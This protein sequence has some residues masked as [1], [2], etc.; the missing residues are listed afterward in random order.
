[1]GVAH[2]EKLRA[3]EVAS[4]HGTFGTQAWHASIVEDTKRSPRRKR[5]RERARERE[6][7][8]EREMRSIGV[9]GRSARRESVC[10]REI[11][12]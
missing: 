2:R 12:R 5:E 11:E 3:R 6:R 7:E 8:R 10:V 4:A 9:Y 1:M